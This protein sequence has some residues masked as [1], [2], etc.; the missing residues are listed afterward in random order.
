MRTVLLIVLI[1]VP[2]L[3]FVLWPLFKKGVGRVEVRGAGAD[4]RAE[5]NEEKLTIYRS[6]GELT[7]D[8]QSGHLSEDDY[9]GLRAQYEGRAAQILKELDQLEPRPPKVETPKPAPVT[10]HAQDQARAWMRS[11]M[12]LTLGAVLILVFGVTLG[13]GVSRFTKP[14]RTFVSPG[15]RLPVPMKAQSSP[16]GRPAGTTSEGAGPIPRETL[17]ATLQAARTSLFEGRYQEAMGAYR[18]VLERDPDN[19]DALTHLS[20]IIAMGGHAD[21]ALESIDRALAIAPDY[22]PAYLYR[23]QILYEN[24]R[25]YAGAIRAWEKFVD[26]VPAGLDRDRVI[27]LIQETQSRLKEQ[28]KVPRAR[29]PTTP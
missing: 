28:S 2:A 13:V 12:A 25:D 26:L 20:V 17:A 21:L 22:P 6:I 27:G 7:F 19:T 24:K 16:S 8:Y 29:A 23:G 9:E 11:P 5:L 14:D 18:A 3:V 1:G 10:P 15:S 4:R